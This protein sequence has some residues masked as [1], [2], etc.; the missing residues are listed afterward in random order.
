[1]KHEEAKVTA[2]DDEEISDFSFSKKVKSRNSSSFGAKNTER[3]QIT[4]QIKVDQNVFSM[5]L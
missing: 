2:V 3:V 4:N 1:M 5:T